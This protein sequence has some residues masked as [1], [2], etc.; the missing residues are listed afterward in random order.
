MAG[1]PGASP[2][3]PGAPSQLPKSMRCRRLWP[4][5]TETTGQDGEGLA[6]GHHTREC[7]AEREGGRTHTTQAPRPPT[8]APAAL[9]HTVLVHVQREE[10]V[11]A[12]QG[13]L[14]TAGLAGAARS[15][16]RVQVEGRLLS[17]GRPQ[18]ALVLELQT[19]GQR[20][21][22]LSGSGPSRHPHAAPKPAAL[23][24]AQRPR[25][26]CAPQTG[27]SRRYTP[28][29]WVSCRL[30]EA[31]SASKSRR[32]WSRPHTSTAETRTEKRAP[33]LSLR[34]SMSLKSQE[35]AQGTMPRLWGELSFP[36]MV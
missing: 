18:L 35:M 12:A 32:L 24:P 16:C 36:I 13:V 34:S 25:R 4:P 14:A 10:H 20:G 33:T 8:S 29:D 5:D 11:R 2:P 28:G 15:Q 9:L 7:P 26:T 30:L 19:D 22:R 17:R 1:P 6:A 31:T 23:L 3:L 21:W 27:S